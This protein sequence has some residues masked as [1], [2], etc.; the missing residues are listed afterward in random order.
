[1]VILKK[2]KRI[3]LIL[4]I[5]ILKHYLLHR[6]EGLILKKIDVLM[7]H[8]LVHLLLNLVELVVSLVLVETT[9]YA[10]K[11]VFPIFQQFM[12]QKAALLKLDESHQGH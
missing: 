10:I 12:A 4:I 2:V 3:V 11:R 8:V 6:V 9:A 1:M 7:A 5:L